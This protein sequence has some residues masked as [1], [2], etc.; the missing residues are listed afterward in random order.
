MAIAFT[1][2]DKDD[3][4][5]TPNPSNI[6]NFKIQYHVDATAIIRDSVMYINAA[7]NQYGIHNLMYYLSE[8]KLTKAD[9]TTHL[10][11]NV[12][13]ADC[14]NP[15]TNQFGFANVPQGIY[16]GISFNIG[17]DSVHNHH[18]VMTNTMEN[19][20]MEWPELMGG[21]YHFLK[22]EGSFIDAGTNYGYAMHVG[23]NPCLVPVTLLK[24]FIVTAD[25]K[26][27]LTLNMNVNE[28]FRSPYDYD[29]NSDG[30]Y[31]MGNMP[32][33]MKLTENGYNAFS[34]Q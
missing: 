21:G 9:G 32:L 23:T 18:Q 13:Y 12:H 29:F 20:N 24:N 26:I 14:F 17:I 6:I 1:A 4:V 30:N 28:W 11:K 3:S 10:L 22:L 31:C 5:T 33:M 16:T 8:I 34:F 27:Q 15:L 19:L 7:G 25:S 2:C